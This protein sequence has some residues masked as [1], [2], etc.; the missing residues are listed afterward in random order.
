MVDIL[1]NKVENSDKKK[2]LKVLL[3]SSGNSSYGISPFVKEQGDAL[4][5]QGIHVDNFLING[6]GIRGYLKNIFRLR[7]YLKRHDYDILHGHFIWSILVCLFQS[8]IIKI[9]TFHGC[10]LNRP[11]FRFVADK[12]VIPKLAISIVVSDK[13]A[14][15][16]PKQKTTV[17][18][19][20]IDIDT[21]CPMTNY[22]LPDNPLIVSGKVNILFCSDFQIPVKNAPLA[23]QAVN[24]LKENYDIN[25][26]ELK[27]LNRSEVNLLLN[28]V[29]LVIMTSFSEGS[30]QIIKE[31]M[32]CN[33][34]V[35]S[36]NVGDVS[37]L[38]GNEEGYFI[39]SHDPVEFAR[40]IDLALQ[41]GTRTHGR[42]RLIQLGLDS[43][44]VAKKIITLYKSVLKRGTV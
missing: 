12:V 10:D 33:C 42:E 32:A 15:L 37:W 27:G 22:V 2:M 5:K 31:A 14:A 16:V 39:S 21:F 35:V 7:K 19:C 11:S 6:K 28:L 25:L 9:G 8:K 36:T 24:L 26:I 4:R 18:P 17:I 34:P 30:P 44:S 40:K 13:M 29:D 1:R 23:F 43:E 20:G 3:V 38:V 41:Y